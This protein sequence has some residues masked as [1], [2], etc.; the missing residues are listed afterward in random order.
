MTDGGVGGLRW[1]VV[2]VA[3]PLAPPRAPAAR[4]LF[5]FPPEGERSE[6][7]SAGW[8]GGAISVGVGWRGQTL[9]DAIEKTPGLAFDADLVVVVE[10]ETVGFDCTAQELDAG[11]DH[12]VV[13]PHV[14]DAVVGQFYLLGAKQTTPQQKDAAVGSDG[15]TLVPCALLPP[16]VGPEVI[17]QTPAAAHPVLN[18]LVVIEDIVELLA[19]AVVLSTGHWGTVLPL[20]VDVFGFAHFQ[21]LIGGGRS[22]G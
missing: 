18:V 13:V 10:V 21:V 20:S 4:A 5:Q 8:D 2:A 3:G 6:G 19:F 1:P 17:G 14:I 12:P 16:K 22:D 7:A 11:G 9:L 15:D